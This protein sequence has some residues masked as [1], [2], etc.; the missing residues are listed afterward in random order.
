M[1]MMTKLCH[2]LFRI[3]AYQQQASETLLQIFCPTVC[4]SVRHRLAC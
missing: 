4:P 1:M 3:V 2:Y